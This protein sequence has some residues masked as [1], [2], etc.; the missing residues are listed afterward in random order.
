M[1]K[2]ELIATATF[3][4]E[5][6]VRRE[7][8]ALGGKILRGE[9]GKVTYLGDEQLLARSNL[10]LR[11]A[12]RVLLKMGEF[13]A[14]SFEELYQQTRALPWEEWIPPDGN[15]PVNGNSVKSKL[16]SI[17][18]CQAIIKKAVVDRLQ[19]TYPIDRFAESGALFPIRFTLLKDRVTLT[20]DSSGT[21]LHKRGYRT[22]D[23]A[24]PIKET[25]AAALVSL[26]FWK[27]D[28]LLVDPFCGSGTIAIE[29]ALIGCNIA[30]GLNRR[31]AC[32]D[33]P[34]IPEKVWQTEKKAAYA[35]IR[36]SNLAIKGY[37]IDPRAVRV[38]QANAEA[39]GV[40]DTIEFAVQPVNQLTAEQPS[41]IIV[42]NP[43]Y[44]ERIG[45]KGQIDQ[46]YRNLNRFISENPDWSLFMVTAD[47]D[48]EKNFRPTPADRRRKL[49]NGRIEICYYQYHGKKPNKDTEHGKENTIPS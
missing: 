39:A 38:A 34:A 11:S 14:L 6:V 21:G 1:A 19:E 46:I 49:Y 13:T 5:A 42:S 30:P 45:D 47:K 16:F 37:D 20:L 23:V 41:G 18:D 3:G 2:L 35:A 33:W 32:Q 10:W 44:G 24:A 48:F 15:F 17:S 12:D 8:E 29:A 26:S 9:D 7:V 25:L 27:P 28:R 36:Q 22:Q 40:D 43:P 31:F 4:L